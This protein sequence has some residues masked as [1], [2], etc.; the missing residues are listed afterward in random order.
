MVCRKR[1]GGPLKSITRHSIGTKN[2]L[3]YNEFEYKRPRM[4]VKYSIV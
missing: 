4:T 3:T 1:L 2:M